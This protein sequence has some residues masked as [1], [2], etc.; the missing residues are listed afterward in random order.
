MPHLNHDLNA[1]LRTLESEGLLR[2]PRIASAAGPRIVVDGHE[3]LN[4]ASN[5]YLGLTQH[6][7]VVAAAQDAAARYGTGAGAS[8]LI[9]GT[10]PV[11][12][13]L[14]H[15][16]ARLKRTEAAIVFSSGYAANLGTVQAL[17]GRGD[18]VI[19]DRLNH[20]SLVDACRL[21]G[22]TLKVY[23]HA[24]PDRLEAVLNR[25]AS[26]RRTLIVT[27][28]V[29][30]MDGDLAPLPGIL[31]LA[32]RCGATVL[33]DDAHGTGCVG[34]TGRGTVE[35]YGADPSRL[36]HMG[37][38]SKALGSLGGFI[39]GSATLIRYLHNRARSFIYS[40]ALAPPCAA[41]ALAGLRLI[42]RDTSRLARLRDNVAALRRGLGAAGLQPVSRDSQITAVVIGAT[43]RAVAFSEA[44]FRRGVFTPAIRPPT[45]PAGTSRLRITVT[46]AHTA[47]DVQVASQALVEAVGEVLQA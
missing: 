43:D 45:V 21:S 25:A 8:R 2:A 26:P 7:E 39:C 34:A 1:D 5:D 31:D 20:A 13:E 35:H 36:I 32:N 37:T 6:P 10:L 47:D 15:A 44:L 42:E 17:V 27:D 12:Q 18:L 33:L 14:E 16:L 24:D 28:G 46:A 38:A 41:A 23:R 11:H 19:C 40:T 30:S 3:C 4:L 9:C 22:A 29:F